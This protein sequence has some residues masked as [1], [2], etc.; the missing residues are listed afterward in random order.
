MA[1][2]VER[3]WLL[4]SGSLVIDRTHVAWNIEPGNPVRFPVFSVLIE[5]T[6]GLFLFDSGFD[7]GT[8]EEF[9][10]FELPEQTDE[11]I[12]PAQLDKCGF[13]PGDVSAVINS[14][15]HFDHCGGQRQLPDAPT[16]VGKEELRHCLVPEQFERLGYADKVFHRPDSVYRWLEGDEIDFADGIRLLHTPGHTVGH[17]S[18]VL[19]REGRAPMLFPADVTYTRET[20]EKEMISGFHNDPTANY[21]SLRRLKHLA[22]RLGAEV[23]FTH[24]M[25]AWETYKHAPDNY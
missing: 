20:W 8:V 1:M 19:E 6:D 10:P 3:V 9:L 21:V 7:K 14:H 15:L 2:G 17:Y 12:V 22:G 25:E 4:D 13:K 11:Q 5:H 16:W 18:L 23:F 24:D